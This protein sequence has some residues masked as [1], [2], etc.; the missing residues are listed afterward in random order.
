MLYLRENQ[1]VKNG[2]LVHSA[3]ANP[4]T[5]LPPTVK[6]VLVSRLGHLNESVRAV[7]EQAA[8][9]GHEF[10]L[11][12]L[13]HAIDGDR[14]ADALEAGAEATIWQPLGR[15][16]Y[17]FNHALLR[18]AAVSTQFATR[19]QELHKRA[20]Q[21]VSKVATA[22]RPQLAALAHHYDEAGEHGRAVN[23][24]LKAGDKARENYFVRE[25]HGYYS[26]GL[27]LATKDKQKLSL[28]LGREAVNHWL[29]NR[30]EQKEDLRQLVGLTADTDDKEIAAEIMLRQVA[31]GLATGDY[32]HAISSAQ[33]TT[34]Q[35]VA[36][37]DRPAN[38]RRPQLLGT[39][40]RRTLSDS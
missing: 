6:N 11:P 32:Q 28:L 35:A 31:Y 38:S 8:V 40:R 5:I 21:A 23:Y 14:L 27:E 12:V 37:N 34:S 22:E 2:R 17:L 29:G 33:K 24:Y 36:L 20:A 26:R 7:V 15:D 3:I 18:E 19:K 4:N 39:A 30:D 25:A 9:L 1:L 16:R 10:S 13:R